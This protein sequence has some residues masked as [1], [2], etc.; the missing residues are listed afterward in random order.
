M[1]SASV[2]LWIAS[3]S[4]LPSTARVACG[5][6]SRPTIVAAGILPASA[7]AS[8]VGRSGV[9]RRPAGPLAAWTAAVA[10]VTSV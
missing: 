3:P 2:Q 4:D 10:R 6:P 1:I 5:A 8:C 7:G 9:A